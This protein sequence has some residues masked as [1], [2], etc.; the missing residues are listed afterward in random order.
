MWRS[1][2]LT[3]TDL[4]KIYFEHMEKYTVKYIFYSFS[5]SIVYLYYSVAWQDT[6]TAMALAFCTAD[7]LS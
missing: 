1:V 6:L 3:I 5:I 2:N 7:N 4:T